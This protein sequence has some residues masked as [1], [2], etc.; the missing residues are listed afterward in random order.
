[1]SRTGI[2]LYNGSPCRSLGK[3]EWVI[4]LGIAVAMPM[5]VSLFGQR[6]YVES[7]KVLYAWERGSSMSVTRFL[8]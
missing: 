2:A 4:P 8:T 3:K 6:D 5:N 7:S 1:M